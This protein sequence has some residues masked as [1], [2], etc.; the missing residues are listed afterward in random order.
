MTQSPVADALVCLAGQISVM[1]C[2][3]DQQ[4]PGQTDALADRLFHL[5]HLA[6]PID[7]QTG[8][9]LDHRAEGL[10][11]RAIVNPFRALSTAELEDLSAALRHAA[12]A[13]REREQNL[14]P[15]VPSGGNVVD[16]R[17]ATARR[18]VA[19]L[20]AGGGDAA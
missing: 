5:S 15:P 1:A 10:R 2:Q 9:R 7:F 4:A 17:A 19:V 11:G 13:L 6:R 16:F 8:I 12:A 3:P 20:P 14:P 18:R